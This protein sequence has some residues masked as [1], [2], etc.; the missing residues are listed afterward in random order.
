MIAKWVSFEHVFLCFPFALRKDFGLDTSTSKSKHLGWH[1]SASKQ[2]SKLE[3]SFTSTSATTSATWIL[4]HWKCWVCQTIFHPLN[5]L[6]WCH[7]LFWLF[8]VHGSPK[9]QD[10]WSMFGWHR[11]KVFIKH[12]LPELWFHQ[13]LG[14]DVAFAW[15][16][17]PPRRWIVEPLDGGARV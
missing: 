8:K 6:G 2:I 4:M 13:S 11:P 17:L 1:T 16:V 10:L 12:G 3:S 14:F 15:A 9:N 7:S 5:L